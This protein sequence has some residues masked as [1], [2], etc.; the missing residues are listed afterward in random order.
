M[1]NDD[2][3]ITLI[4]SK[5]PLYKNKTYFKIFKDVLI[6]LT[7]LPIKDENNNIIIKLSKNK[8]NDKVSINNS[9]EN[10]SLWFKIMKNIFINIKIKNYEFKKKLLIKNKFNPKIKDEFE[11]DYCYDF[12][13][14][15]NNQYEISKL[16]Y[17]YLANISK[18]KLQKLNF[19]SQKEKIPLVNIIKIYFGLCAKNIG[20]LKIKQKKDDDEKNNENTSKKLLLRGFTLIDDDD[21]K[22]DKTLKFKKPTNE[23]KLFNNV[24]KIKYISNLKNKLAHKI[25]NKLINSKNSNFKENE[26]NNS[27]EKNKKEESNNN[28]FDKKEENKNSF[29][30]DLIN[31]EF[32]KSIKNLNGKNKNS[33]KILY[34]SSFTR[35]FIGEV[36]IASIKERYMS[37]IDAKKEE[38]I[39]KKNKKSSLFLR[40]IQNGNNQLPLIEKNMKNVWT[41]FMKN[42]EIIEKFK[43]INLEEKEEK[44]NKDE[45]INYT[46]RTDRKRFLTA[47]QFAKNELIKNELDF[48]IDINKKNNFISLS[49]KI[50]KIIKTPE[51]KKEIIEH[52]N[53]DDIIKNKINKKDNSSLKK[54]GIKN[55]FKPNDNNKNFINEYAAKKV[56][57]NELKIKKNLFYNSNKNYLLTERNNSSKKSNF[58]RI[59]EEKLFRNKQ[60]ENMHFKA[61]SLKNN[62]YRGERNL[63]G[64]LDKSKN[65]KTINFFTKK[66][67][68]F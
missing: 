18:I 40:I 7:M 13:N 10:N 57:I 61:L 2:G 67:F 53:K 66:D 11:D 42:Q 43:R 14:R 25:S 63:Y 52:N 58:K 29:E 34:S 8:S 47:A 16:E 23:S 50:N 31:D 21:N 5:V 37:I 9:Y 39:G 19:I 59:F 41:K 35:L 64:K 20:L 32:F 36:D 27:S 48:N 3:I 51:R 55:F 49:S 22:K 15:K 46:D 12:Y 56:N 68:Y 38:K 65:Q 30:D 26:R 33:L 45:K 28:S 54:R 60:N 24:V 6:G 44:K 62:N 17:L 1:K 4:Q